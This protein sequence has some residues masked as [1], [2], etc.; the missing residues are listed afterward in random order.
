MAFSEP[1]QIVSQIDIQK[2]SHVADIGTGTGFYSFAAAQ[3]VGPSGRVFALDV[4]KDLLERLKHEATQRGLGNITTVWVDAE[5]PNGTRLRDTSINL[6]ILANIFFQA[7]DKDGLIAEVKRI[8]AP[9]GSVLIVDWKESFGGVGPRFD[10]VFDQKQAE[11]FF[12][13]QGFSLVKN[14][15][16]GEHHYGLLYSK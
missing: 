16:A 15:N 10:Q 12:N 4:Q 6:V 2:G 7:E 13:D 5:K 8:L 1:E 3:A 11:Q 14:I 9:G